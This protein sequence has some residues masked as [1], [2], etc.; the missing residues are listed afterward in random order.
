MILV[1]S[2]L[3]MAQ[4]NS[5]YALSEV[6]IIEM[7]LYISRIIDNNFLH[8]KQYKSICILG[9]FYIG[10]LCELRIILINVNITSDIICLIFY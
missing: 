10:R 3:K 9:P 5:D 2:N 1:M 8:F 7:K 4:S 6:N